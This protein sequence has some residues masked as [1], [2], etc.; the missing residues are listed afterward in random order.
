MKVVIT[1]KNVNANDR[2]KDTIE[3][4]MEKLSKYFSDNIIVNVTL[5]AE[6]NRQKIEATIRVRGMIF[7]AE[8]V[9]GDMYEGVDNVVEKLSTQ[10]SRFK[11]KIQKKHKDNKDFVFA[12]WPEEVQEEIKV[13]KTKKFEL[14][15]MT[16]DEAILQMEMLEHNFFVFLNMET[17]SVNVVYKRKDDD[18]GLL[19][20][21]Y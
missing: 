14:E 17:D 16:T 15:P 18:Y 3:K 1:S 20:T 21:T 8:D 7:R 11:T 4:K 6:K 9:S 5:S 2:L 19:E 13:V 10:M 12:D